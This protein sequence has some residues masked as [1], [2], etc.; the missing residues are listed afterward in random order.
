M[1]SPSYKPILSGIFMTTKFMLYYTTVV[2]IILHC[3]LSPDLT[4][5]THHSQKPEGYIHLATTTVSS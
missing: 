1:L 4:L 5:E 2:M 3:E